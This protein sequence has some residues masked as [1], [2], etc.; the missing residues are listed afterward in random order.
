MS[1]DMEQFEQGNPE[2]LDVY[3]GL[4]MDELEHAQ[5]L[6]LNLTDLVTQAA[7][8]STEANSDGADAGVFAA[9]DL[10]DTAGEAGDGEGE[11]EKKE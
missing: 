6:T 9:G 2:L 10:T 4:R 5:V 1:F 7:D 11:G 3:A 8:E